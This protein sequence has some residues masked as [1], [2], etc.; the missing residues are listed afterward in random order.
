MNA[1]LGVSILFDFLEQHPRL[2]IERH[3]V[4]STEFVNL[5]RSLRAM[6]AR[7]AASDDRDGCE[8]AARLRMLV[9]EWLTVP[10]PF[11][12][13]ILEAVQTIGGREAVSSRWGEEIGAAYD[14]A[15]EAARLLPMQES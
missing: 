12:D 10:V 14:A 2:R 1:M 6:F 4:A 11:D 8:L 13:S 5:R 15:I 9:S 3:E 7:L